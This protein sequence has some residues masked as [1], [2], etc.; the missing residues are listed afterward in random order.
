MPMA[1][2]LRVPRVAI[3]GAGTLGRAFA[4]AARSIDWKIA[5]IASEDTS[6]ADDL[7]THLDAPRLSPAELVDR[8]PDVAVVTSPPDR[9]AAEV[10]LLAPGG[11]AVL[12]AAPLAPTLAE[13]RAIGG[14]VARSGGAL[15]L[16]EPVVSSPAVQ[17]L[18]AGVARMSTPLRHL[19]AVSRQPPPE[20]TLDDDRCDPGVG[21]VLFH[22]GG[23]SLATL[24]LAARI[25]GWGAPTEVR[26]S[27]DDTGDRLTLGFTSGHT[28]GLDIAWSAD[29]TPTWS[30]QAAGD[31]D[32][33]RVEMHPRP[34]LELNGTEM[35]LPGRRLGERVHP[36]DALGFAPT[37]RLFADD[38]R[39]RRTPLLDVALATTSWEIV[40]AAHASAAAASAIPLP[41]DD[42]LHT[43]PAAIGGPP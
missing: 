34:S 29:G 14:V 37:L 33:Y 35:H 31:A 43:V 39:Q 26:A 22:R 36:A 8:R 18:L 3:I 2:P 6:A 7:A 40:A 11:C 12:L 19:S 38:V 25:A 4:A 10:A 9:H 23:A 30:V 1:D 27:I 13:C 16:A 24:V 42:E 20:A 41:Y 15:A 28:A 21:G 17:Q 32:V 5:G